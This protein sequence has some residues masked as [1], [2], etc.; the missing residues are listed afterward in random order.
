MD[1][2]VLQSFVDGQGEIS[3]HF[4]LG[5]ESLLPQI[6]RKILGFSHEIVKLCFLIPIWGEVN[7]QLNRGLGG[8]QAGQGF[9]VSRRV[10]SCKVACHVRR[11]AGCPLIS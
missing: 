3:P 8:F 1:T 7:A 4:I 9:P 10:Y 5:Q 6:G 11:E 2:L